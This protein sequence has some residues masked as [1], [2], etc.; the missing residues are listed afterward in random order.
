MA[1]LYSAGVRLSV[2]ASGLAWTAPPGIV[3]PEVLALLRR[4][5]AG[6]VD[7][8][9]WTRQTG[10]RT[11]SHEADAPLPTSTVHSPTRKDA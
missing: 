8:I 5:K 1:D 9:R 7:F 11:N 3:T 6:I 2:V 10:E 4:H